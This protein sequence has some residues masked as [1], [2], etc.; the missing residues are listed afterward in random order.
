[1]DFDI[2]TYQPGLKIISKKAFKYMTR[3]QA[4]LNKTLT[5]DQ[6]TCL[7]AAIN[8]LSALLICLNVL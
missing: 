8:A 4:Q 1:M 5:D 2:I 3:Y 7:T 6:K